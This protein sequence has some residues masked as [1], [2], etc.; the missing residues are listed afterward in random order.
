MAFLNL[1]LGNEPALRSDM[2]IYQRLMLGDELEATRLILLK[3]KSAP[4]GEV[5]DELL[6]PTLSYAKR[7]FLR[8]QLSE[9]DR[10]QVLDGVNTTLG[11][12]EEF[13][14][15]SIQRK[16]D[17]L[18]AALG[19]GPAPLPVETRRVT[20]FACPAS[21]ASDSTA[22]VMLRQALDPAQWNIE[23][24]A[25]ETLT[26][27]LVARIAIDPPAI[28]YVAALPPRGLA[29]ARYLCKRLHDSSPELQIV[30]GRWGQKRDSKLEQEQLQ[31][32][33]ATFVTT[34]LVETIQ[35]LNSRLPLLARDLDIAAV[36][37]PVPQIPTLVS[38]GH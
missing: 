35:L 4:I 33:G 7:D 1:L 20:M 19:E 13:L 27:E 25:I 8:E 9:E 36:S 2:G 34:S 21:D 29:H 24:T 14:T 5:F 30:V 37:S 6:I 10:K 22:L 38:A 32:A 31:E 26:S 28:L 3:M 15:N 12:T 11:H 23:Q 17:D 18:K 16:I